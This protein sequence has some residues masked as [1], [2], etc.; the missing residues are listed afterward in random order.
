MATMQAAFQEGRF[1]AGI[2]QAVDAV[3]ALLVRHFPLAEGDAQP[4]R[5]A[6]RAGAALIAAP[7]SPEAGAARRRPSRAGGSGQVQRTL[8]AFQAFSSVS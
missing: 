2:E 8:P 5:A 6:R 4:E 3:D 7:A 1:A